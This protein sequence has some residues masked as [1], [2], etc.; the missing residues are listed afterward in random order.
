MARV[1]IAPDKFKGT[2]TAAEV[3]AFVATGMRSVRSD[4]AID[5]VPVADGGDGT[6]AAAVAA[7]FTRVPVLASGPT[8]L[9]VGSAYARRGTDAV[10]ELAE[11]SGLGQLPE[12]RLAPDIASS[13]GTGDLIAAALHD[14]CRRI[15]IGIGGS[16]C[17]DGGAGL[18]AALV[19]RLTRADGALVDPGGVALAEATQLDLSALNPHLV[20]AEIIVACDVDNPLLGE[21]GAAAVYGPQKGATA[22]QVALLERGL[23]RFAGLVTTAIRTDHT[24]APGAGAAG[25]VG[26][27]AIAVLGA[28]LRPGIELILELTGF[29]ETLQRADLV[30]TGEG[31]LDEQTLYGKAPAGVAAAACAAGIPI[32][33]VCGRNLLNEEQLMAAGFAAAYPLTDESSDLQECL[34]KPGPL[35]V[36]IGRR[37]AVDHLAG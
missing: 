34:T 2:L 28:R 24:R 15:V 30:V 4:L 16:A 29:H 14:G 5:I 18:L 27:A 3:A 21:K 31:S 37:I 17:T 12:G 33:A 26:F 13:R 19:A 22:E 23:E 9:P 35:L 11:V 8:G 10:V 32:V 1:L 6:L 7:G 25:G 20:D 36:R